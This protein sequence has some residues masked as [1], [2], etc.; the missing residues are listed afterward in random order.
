MIVRVQLPPFPT[1]CRENP[2][3][4]ASVLPNRQFPLGISMI[5]RV[6]FPS[7]LAFLMADPDPGALRTIRILRGILMVPELWGG[8]PQFPHVRIG[9]LD[10]GA[11]TSK[12]IAIPLGILMIPRVRFSDFPDILKIILDSGALGTVDIPRGMR[13]I[14][15]ERGGCH[16]KS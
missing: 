9:K 4:G 6:R 7:F 5:L 15:E 13:L 12:D 16:R 11:H 3:C 8:L 10:P 1:E 14:S 2:P